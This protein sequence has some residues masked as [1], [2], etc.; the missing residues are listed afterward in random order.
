MGL[1]QLRDL[2]DDIATMNVIGALLRN[3]ILLSEVSIKEEDFNNNF[4]KNIFSAIY[5]LTA[6]GADKVSIIDIDN[7]LQKYDMAYANFTKNNG[8]CYLQD[9]LDI[10]S[11]ANFN[12]Y[13]MRVKKFSLLRTLVRAEIG[14]SD[15]YPTNEDDP[16]ISKKKLEAFD[17][18]TLNDI[19]THVNRKISEVEYAYN[20]SSSS[21]GALVTGL[22]SLK[23]EFKKAPEVGPSLPGTNYNKICRGARKGKYYLNSAGTG[24]GKSRNMIGNACYLAFPKRY[25]WISKTWEETG[26]Q[27]RVLIITTELTKDEVET[28][29]M[30]NVSGLNEEKILYATYTSEEEQVL[31]E[32]IKMIED[33]STLF[34]EQ[35]PDPNIDEIKAVARRH[36]NINEIENLFYDYIYSSPNLLGEFR[37]IKIREDV[38]L[39]MLSTALKDIAV[40]NNIY[41]ESAT[42]LSGEYEQYDGIRSQIWLRGAKA[43]ADKA[44]AGCITCETTLKQ[45]KSVQIICTTNNLPTPTHVR[46]IYKLRRGRYKSVRIWGTIDL[47]T[48]RWEDFFVTND[49]YKL[50]NI[51]A[52]EIRFIHNSEIEDDSINKVISDEETK[53]ANELNLEKGRKKDLGW[54]LGV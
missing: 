37:D 12:Y 10:C 31:D 25:N 17:A 40:D 45:K 33:C 27:E 32:A 41:V 11:L 48:G 22:A 7:Y 21:G 13:A 5:N 54:N 29:V 8:I 35:I 47:G 14:I 51:T 42:Q 23:D 2:K 39:T 18:M 46:D 38:I 15:I 3:P 4:T 52:P 43:I 24:A 19:I 50:I 6:L 34:I 26:N 53:K 16:I 9:C 20:V 1:K 36:I 49:S 28:I 44:D 30:A